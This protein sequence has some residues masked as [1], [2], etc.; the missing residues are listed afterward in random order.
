MNI[1][2]GS[3]SIRLAHGAGGILQEELIHFITKN[4]SRKRINQGI[5]VEEMDDGAT[6]PLDK[7]DQELVITADG[8][9]VHPLFFPGGDLG[10]LSICGTVNDLLMMGADP[11]ALTSIVI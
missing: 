5:G 11:L 1:K 2:E 10:K 7:L 8:H 3:K 6:I 4:I 9:T